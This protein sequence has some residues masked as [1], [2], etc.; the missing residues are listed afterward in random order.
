M[1]ALLFTFIFRALSRL[2][3]PLLH[4]LGGVLGRVVYALSARYRSHLN[5]HL[6]YAFGGAVPDD[7]RQQAVREAGKA[8]LELPWLWLR[9]RDQVLAKIDAV[10]GMEHVQ[11]AWREGCGIVYLTPH[12]GCFDVTAM[13][14]AHQCPIT[15][16]YRPPRQTWLA[17]LME[18]GR[19]AGN[20]RLAPANLTGVRRM[21]KALRQ[22]EAVGLLP[23]QAPGVGEGIWA[24][25]FGHPA[26]TMTLAARL[27]EGDVQP[28]LVWGE[29]LPNGAGYRLHFEPLQLSKTS[30]LTERTVEINQA[31]EQLIMRCPQ[32]Y[33]WA[34]NRYKVPAGAEP[35]PKVVA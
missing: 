33:L 5:L 7:I 23:D 12:L 29:R 4:G 6:G 3:L 30:D 10:S 11:Q 25:F 2:P 28:I 22:R 8:V 13:Y 20:M 17:P 26:Y 32:Q 31:I 35:P 14:L 1:R 19:G 18:Q 9:P 24:P 15:V 16:L 21:I 27:I 34:Y